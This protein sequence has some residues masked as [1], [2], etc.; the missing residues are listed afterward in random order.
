MADDG[1]PVEQRKTGMAW[2]WFVII[3]MLMLMP[4]RLV[5]SDRAA[6]ASLAALHA[7]ASTIRA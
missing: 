2:G 7:D 1:S 3:H 6:D 4:S 5:G